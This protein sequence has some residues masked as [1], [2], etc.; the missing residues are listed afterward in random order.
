MTV[1]EFSFLLFAFCIHLGQVNCFFF[2]VL[3][4]EQAVHDYAI[5][6]PILLAQF[7]KQE[8]IRYPKIMNFNDYLIPLMTASNCHLVIDNYQKINL[9]LSVPAILR[10][11]A[12]GVVI[13]E[14][15]PY[16]T[17]RYK[18]RRIVWYPRGIFGGNDSTKY[19]DCSQSNLLANRYPISVL[20]GVADVCLRV[21]LSLFTIK[22]KPWNCHLQVGIYPPVPHKENRKLSHPKSIFYNIKR[23]HYPVFGSSSLSVQPLHILILHDDGKL[24]AFTIDYLEHW[25][26]NIV[27]F[28]KHDRS[29]SMPYSHDIFL[30]LEVSNNAS[31]FCSLLADTQ[32]EIKSAVVLKICPG[33][34]WDHALSTMRVDNPVDVTT[35]GV[36]HAFPNANER[37]FIQVKY[38]LERLLDFFR[39]ANL[40][41][42]GRIFNG[43]L[44]CQ[45][46]RRKPVKYIQN[47]ESLA[48]AY[49]NMFIP[50]LTNYTA[51]LC[52]PENS[53]KDIKNPESAGYKTSHKHFHIH[54][55]AIQ[56]LLHIYHFPFFEQRPLISMS[57]VSCGRPR[58]E[59]LLFH[60]LASVFDIPTWALLLISI[61]SI[62]IPLVAYSNFVN[63]PTRNLMTPVMTFLEQGNPFPDAT[64]RLS[65]YRVV[66]ILFFLMSTV[67][68]NAYKNNNVY[69][70]IAPRKPVPYDKFFKLVHDNF[71]I[72]GRTSYPQVYEGDSKAPWQFTVDNELES[73]ISFTA[74]DF[75]VATETLVESEMHGAQAVSE[76]FGI[77]YNKTEGPFETY[78]VRNY[79]KL[80]IIQ[81]CS[82]ITQC[83]EDF[84]E[85]IR[86]KKNLRSTTDIR[87]NISRH[88]QKVELLGLFGK[89]EYC[90]KVAVVLPHYMSV[91]I[92]KRLKK[93]THQQVYVGRERYLEVD[94]VPTVEG[95]IP[96]YIIKR[97]KSLGQSGMWQRWMSLLLAGQDTLNSDEVSEHPT[98][99]SLDG[100]IVVIFV[101]WL[102]GVS[103]GVSCCMI[104]ATRNTLRKLMILT[105]VRP[106]A[107]KPRG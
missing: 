35:A 88:I 31:G 87:A 86:G 94:W 81:I 99:A 40:S 8:N 6:H 72:F 90:D 98:A 61:V 10:H 9:N 46:N 43:L 75:T 70:M 64:L 20:I 30:I 2:Q 104:E 29:T 28:A 22:S 91:N 59:P 14:Y 13:A 50:F 37:K 21:N 19:I 93:R 38:R 65:K 89:L 77:K 47:V 62:N 97:F 41:P 52:F 12:P 39:V 69:N 66:A 15:Q 57:F 60:E 16:V 33:C 34:Q 17:T 78:G 4:T 24:S 1:P 83:A 45:P 103:M 96:P 101:T 73:K 95:H 27:G 105:V 58:L 63:D 3:S 32:A 25:I 53:D 44:S 82:T 42:L 71:T 74:P 56:Y 23:E 55:N 51:E 49:A 26:V 85:L 79:T 68:S 5:L 48:D 7:I 100:N 67:L 11:P 107:Q 36:T 76:R 84:Q 80:N 18:Q 106:V 102:F 92:S 54:L